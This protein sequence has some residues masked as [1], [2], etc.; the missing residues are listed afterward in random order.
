M[1]S[2]PSPA[3]QVTRW[4][5]TKEPIDLEKLRG[6][7]IVLHAFQML[8]PG[9]VH[10]AIPQ[11]QR[12]YQHFNPAHVAVIGLH[13]VF[14]HHDVMTEQALQVFIQENRLTFPIGVDMPDGKKGMPITMSAYKMQG[15]PT[16]ILID[17]QGRLRLNYLGPL[18]DLVIGA[19]IGKLMAETENN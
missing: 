2:P 17:R 7:I 13:T 11:M 19:E 16:M 18:D 5:N 4:F 6:K 8:C 14:E 10:H 1:Y 9:C 3:L 12:I 15:T